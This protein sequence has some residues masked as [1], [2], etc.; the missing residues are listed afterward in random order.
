MKP[1]YAILLCCAV[2][3]G[4][5]KSNA[6]SGGDESEQKV[7]LGPY[8]PPLGVLAPV[9]RT[10]TVQTSGAITGT[11]TG[12][13]GEELTGLRGLCN[14]QMWANFM[15]SMPGGKDFDEVWVTNM[16]K[17]PVATGATGDFRLDYIE[18]TFRRTA[19]DYSVTQREFRGPGTMTLTTHDAVPGHRRL[20]GTMT[21]TGLQGKDDDE[22]KTLD[23]KV[24]FDMDSSC[25]LKQQ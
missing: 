8:G 10:V 25:G 7:E 5:G 13:K 19:E 6:P 23:V 12:H 14:P 4:C 16:S 11:F 9:V 22:G 3:A 18:V 21:G 2:L 15:L 24:S 20:V 1:V 17:G